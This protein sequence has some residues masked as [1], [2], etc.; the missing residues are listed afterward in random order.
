MTVTTV[1]RINWPGGVQRIAMREVEL[2]R[3]HGIKAEAVFLRCTHR[4]GTQALSPP[5]HIQFPQSNRSGAIAHLLRLITMHFNPERGPDA[6]VDLDLILRYELNRGRQDLVIY[7]D[8]LAASFAPLGHWLHGDQYAVYIHESAFKHTN[9]LKRIQERFALSRA[10]LVFTNAERNKALI[11]SNVPVSVQ[12]LYPGTDGPIQNMLPFGQRIDE[13]ISVTMWD[14]GRHPEV[15]VEVARHLTVGRIVLAGNWADSTEMSRVQ[16]LI[17]L[18]GVSGRIVITGPL[19]EDELK[20]RYKVAKAAIRFGYD[21]IG[22]GMSTLE[23]ISYGLPLIINLGVG[24]KEV[25][26]D[27]VNAIF[28]DPSRPEEIARLLERLFTDAGHWNRMSTSSIDLSKN[29]SWDRHGNKLVESVMEV[30]ARNE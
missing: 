16:R 14:S 26:Q 24:F 18:A 21:E 4:V 5:D 30:L 9:R 28:A 3:R 8:Q 27:S 17:E 23:A 22:P 10:R 15:F 6:T 2:L 25:A 1:V 13:A 29:L 20:A 11:E 12:V 19:A 7:S